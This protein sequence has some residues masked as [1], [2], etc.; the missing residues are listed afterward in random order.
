[1]ADNAFKLQTPSIA[2]IVDLYVEAVTHA[3]P[4]QRYI[5]G[6]FR[7]SSG[8]IV[9]NLAIW[10]QI[11]HLPEPEGVKWQKGHFKKTD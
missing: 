7:K 10:W 1:M 5:S 4:K 6:Q 11:R 8:G 2:S 3:Y 9:D